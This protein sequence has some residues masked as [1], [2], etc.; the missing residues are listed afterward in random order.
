[1]AKAPLTKDLVDDASLWRLSLLI[2]DGSVDV[3]AH[4]IVGDAPI[5]SA[6]LPFD[7]AA[8]ST[9][10]AVEEV[11]YANPLLLAPFGKTDIVVRTRRFFILPPE[12][13]GDPDAVESLCEIFPP[14]DGQFT[15]CVSALDS[16]NAVVFLLDKGVANFLART[17]DSSAPRHV[18]SALGQYFTHK[19]RLGNS[20]KMYVNL[21]GASLD[22]LVYDN[23]GLVAANTIEA[24]TAENAAYFILAIGR[25]AGLEPQTSEL[26]IAGDSDRRSSLTPML[27]RFI[28]YVMPAIFPSAAYHGDP[29]ALKAS[30]PLVILPLCE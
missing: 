22:I 8:S 25:T 3:L 1:M 2:G 7:P 16:R 19:S 4:K 9:A 28:D 24:P 18:L 11:I 12:V 26:M 10:A 6:R 17:Y 21:D 5:V 29:N 30:F 15:P 20:S 23:I 13:A 27:R 14:G